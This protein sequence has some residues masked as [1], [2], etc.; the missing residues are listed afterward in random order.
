M[1]IADPAREI[2]AEF[3]AEA[4]RISA[5]SSADV[6]G[7]VIGDRFLHCPSAPQV[8]VTGD[9]VK[10]AAD[11]P[12]GS[13]ADRDDPRRQPLGVQLSSRTKSRQWLPRCS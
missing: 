12:T 10:A 2:G 4:G 5:P 6:T 7:R 3:G 9:T 8:L 11:A 1:V 13:H